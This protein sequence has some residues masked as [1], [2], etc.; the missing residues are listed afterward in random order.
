MKLDHYV[1]ILSDF[2][3]ANTSQNNVAYHNINL[4]QSSK[5]E[6][7]SKTINKLVLSANDG[8]R[9]ILKDGIHTLAHGNYQLENKK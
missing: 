7:F 6:V 4:I 2:I 9:F 5:H 3:N 1:Q 8:E